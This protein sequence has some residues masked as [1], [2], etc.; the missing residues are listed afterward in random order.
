[1]QTGGRLLGDPVALIQLSE[2]KAAGIRGYPGP[3][4]SAM[5]SLLK[6]LSKMS[7]LW[8]SVSIGYPV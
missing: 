3:S 8:Q 1:M 7:C 6:R 2:Q 5:T 4:K